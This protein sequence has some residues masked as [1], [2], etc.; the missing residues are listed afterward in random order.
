[1]IR[2]CSY[3]IQKGGHML[4]ACPE[5]KSQVSDK[6]MMCPHC[7]YPLDSKEVQKVRRN[8]KK[9]MKLPNGFGQITEIK[10]RNLRTPFRAMVTIRRNTKNKMRCMNGVRTNHFLLLIRTPIH[11][12]KR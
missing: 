6:A 12:L 4:T 10:D 2:I 8:T 7:G 1:M 11:T 9:R 3:I 5:C